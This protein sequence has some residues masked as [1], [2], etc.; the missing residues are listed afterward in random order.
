MPRNSRRMI[1]DYKECVNATYTTP[2][3]H[4]RQA[5][6]SSLLGGSCC[7]VRPFLFLLFLMCLEPPRELPPPLQV[8]VFRI[9]VLTSTRNSMH[10]ACVTRGHDH[11]SASASASHLRYRCPQPHPQLTPGLALVC[12][13][14]RTPRSLCFDI[15]TMLS[16]ADS[17]H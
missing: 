10:I 1:N 16:C 3:T 14:R 7:G 2:S 13:T 12:R 15:P 8:R 9:L 17:S 11:T 4:T 5:S 6:H